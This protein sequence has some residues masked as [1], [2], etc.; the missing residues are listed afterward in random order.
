MSFNDHPIFVTYIRGVELNRY[1]MIKRLGKG[2]TSDV[3]L[4]RKL[5]SDQKEY[6]A[7]KIFNSEYF[8]DE[9][10]INYLHDEI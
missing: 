10:A 4:A 5:D 6:R 3:Y 1:Q 2:A 9:D 7:I 8:E